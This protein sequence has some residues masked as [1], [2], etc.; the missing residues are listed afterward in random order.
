MPTGPVSSSQCLR[1][2][3]DDGTGAQILHAHDCLRRRAIRSRWSASCTLLDRRPFRD[4]PWRHHTGQVACISMGCYGSRS[5]L[6]S[7]KSRK[8]GDLGGREL[9]LGH[10]CVRLL[11][12]RIAEPADQVTLGV[13]GADARQVGTYRG[14]KS[15]DPVAAVA[16]V[17]HEE[18]RACC[19]GGAIL[20]PRDPG[21][22]E[23]GGEREAECDAESRQEHCPVTHDRTDT[24]CRCHD[25]LAQ[26]PSDLRAMTARWPQYPC[27]ELA[28]VGHRLGGLL[29]LKLG[30]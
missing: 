3:G 15:T 6:G 26:R 7:E 23:S 8:G 30:P 13:L 25:S 2:D 29:T 5:A 12:C 22:A 14:A 10:V 21:H 19:H 20:S 16:A 24:Q 17:L 11:R 27:P 18:M 4:G 9:E 1:L 28:A